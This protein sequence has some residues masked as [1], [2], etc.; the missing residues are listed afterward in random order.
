MVESATHEW[1]GTLS[2]FLGDNTAGDN[3]D[4]G[5]RMHLS[6]MLLRR[7]DIQVCYVIP[8]ARIIL[9]ISKIAMHYT[10]QVYRKLNDVYIS[11]IVI[12]IS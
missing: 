7:S 3:G 6:P 4:V 2:V 11:S 5:V 8:L 12:H 10:F 1:R 9:S